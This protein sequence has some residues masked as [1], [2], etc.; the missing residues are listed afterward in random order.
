VTPLQ[1]RLEAKLK[2][3][4][5]EARTDAELA[6]MLGPWFHAAF[7]EATGG[8]EWLRL[9][10]ESREHIAKIPR[11]PPPPP[12]GAVTWCKRVIRCSAQATCAIWNAELGRAEPYCDECAKAFGPMERMALPPPKVATKPGGGTR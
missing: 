10:D 3:F 4:G 8:E 1:S 2:E 5:V 12:P 11:P 9:L 7:A 6:R